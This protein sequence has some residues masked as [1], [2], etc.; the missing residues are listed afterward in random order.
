V[1][2]RQSGIRLRLKR[3]VDVAVAGVGLVVTAPLV[4]ATAAA[5]WASMG[6]PVLFTQDRVGRGERIFRIKKFRSMRAPTSPDEAD[7]DR[8]TRVGRFIRKTSLDELPQLANILRGDMSLV[9][10]RPLLVRYLP[11]YSERQRRRHEVLPGI[12]GWAQ[13][14]GRNALGWDEKFERDVWYVENWSLALDLRIL[15]R[16]ALTVVRRDGISSEGHVTMPEFMGPGAAV[17]AG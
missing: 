15:A 12:T 10:P 11:R 2:V 14:N 6:R 8:I 1:R 5:V 9:G 17:A 3:G 4:A 13:V 7:D 16:T